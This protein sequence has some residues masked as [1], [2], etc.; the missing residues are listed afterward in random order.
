MAKI[1]IKTYRCPNCGATDN[2]E[3]CLRPGDYGS[4]ENETF[5]FDLDPE[6]D[7]V[8]GD[9]QFVAMACEECGHRSIAEAFDPDT[10]DQFEPPPDARVSAADMDR[11]V[12]D[13]ES[14]V[15][16]DPR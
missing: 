6:A 8:T 5:S 2:A 10:A 14:Q 11:M 13:D 15:A 1:Q 12:R 9:R 4:S 16:G 7:H 3:I